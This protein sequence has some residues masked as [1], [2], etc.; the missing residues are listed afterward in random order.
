MTSARCVSSSLAVNLPSVQL[1]TPGLIAEVR[2]DLTESR[3]APAR[4]ALNGAASLAAQ[5]DPAP[6]FPGRGD[7]AHRKN[8]LSG[9]I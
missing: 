1:R 4:L 2:C 8:G 9:Y 7:R 3:L 5:D 6:I